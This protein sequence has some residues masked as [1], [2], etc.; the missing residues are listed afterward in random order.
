MLLFQE[1][2]FKSQA[3]I[4]EGLTARQVEMPVTISNN[5]LVIDMRGFIAGFALLEKSYKDKEL[6]AEMK[7]KHAE[8]KQM[9]CDSFSLFSFPFIEDISPQPFVG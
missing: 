5:Q 7:Q 1:K 9:V 3:E 6:S 4:L 8:L 2:A